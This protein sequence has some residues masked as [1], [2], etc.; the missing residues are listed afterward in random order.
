MLRSTDGVVAN[1]RRD[2]VEQLGGTHAEIADSLSATA[3]AGAP[4]Y[5]AEDDPSLRAI[6][7][8]AAKAR[9]GWLVPVSGKDISPSERRGFSPLAFPENIA[10]ALAIASRHGVPRAVALDG[11]RAARPDPG[12]SKVHRHALNERALFWI[13]LFG[14][15]DV[16]SAEMN[17]RLIAEWIG[18][19]GE[20][21][22]VINN[23]ADRQSRSVQFAG[24][25]AQHSSAARIVLV[26]ERVS[27][28]AREILARNPGARTSTPRIPDAATPVDIARVT[29]AGGGHRAAG[30][31]W[32]RQHSHG[33]C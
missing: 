21:V 16:E 14:V 17:V 9:D 26:G 12:A 31:R 18:D 4:L 8:S 6:L 25:A 30:D 7:E 2:H 27:I 24:M 23:R 20:L 10:L 5:T 15:N 11:I 28:L 3:P 29:G 32:S 33:G 19:E 1:V 22:F 13:D